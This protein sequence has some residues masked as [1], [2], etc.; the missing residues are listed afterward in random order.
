[1]AAEGE[2]YFLV[3]YHRPRLETVQVEPE[4]NRTP[5]RMPTSRP[6]KAAGRSMLQSRLGA[7][8][9]RGFHW[10]SPGPLTP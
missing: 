7:G 1:M 3:P 4:W 10:T 5:P 8:T 2:L 6:R 9:R